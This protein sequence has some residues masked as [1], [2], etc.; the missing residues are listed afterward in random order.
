MLAGAIAAVPAD[1]WSP[2]VERMQMRVVLFLRYG[3]HGICR[4]RCPLLGFGCGASITSMWTH[5]AC[6]P[7][8]CR[9]SG[10]TAHLLISL[11]PMITV[12]VASGHMSTITLPYHDQFSTLLLNEPFDGFLPFLLLPLPVQLGVPVQ[13]SP[14]RW[15][16]LVLLR[17]PR[18]FDAILDGP[19]QTSSSLLFFLSISLLVLP[20]CF[21]SAVL[22]LLLLLLLMLL[23]PG[24]V[25]PPLPLPLEPLLLA[26]LQLSLETPLS[27]P[28]LL[29]FGLGLGFRGGGGCCSCLGGP[30][31]LLLT[32]PASFSFSITIAIPSTPTLTPLTVPIPPP[33][34]VVDGRAQAG[35]RRGRGPIRSALS[36][37][38]RRRGWL[39]VVVVVASS[40]AS[41]GTAPSV[42]AMSPIMTIIAITI[43]IIS[44]IASTSVASPASTTAAATD[45]P[46]PPPLPIVFFAVVVV[47]VRVV[48]EGVPLAVRRAD[49]V[50]DDLL[51]QSDGHFVF[52]FAFLLVVGRGD[53]NR[54]F[55]SVSKI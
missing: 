37:G 30:S 21:V 24:G 3:L 16:M 19:S 10:E 32:P 5:P 23:R 43:I 36:L 14:R 48:R 46:S 41:A 42:S 11:L 45:I 29:P 55:V 54:C 31:L 34:T 28:L 26:L 20:I 51:E 33:M 39:V 12:R 18:P 13:V 50:L 53:P 22:L 7:S 17:M 6:H 52:L 40:P 35:A 49:D 8:Q 44:I 47:V 15:L 9:G 27:L 2:L 25:L 38:R 4:R 1:T